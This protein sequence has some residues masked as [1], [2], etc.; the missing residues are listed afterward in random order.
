MFVVM[1]ALSAAPARAETAQ[2]ADVEES[3]VKDPSYKVRVEAAL[4][5][6]KLHQPRSL[7]ALLAGARDGHPAV[8]TASVRALGLTGGPGARDAV[9]AALRD[10]APGV[11]HRPRD[12]LRSLGGIDE[13]TPTAPGEP[14][15]RRRPGRQLSFEIRPVGDPRNQA[16]PLLRS[17]MRDFLMQQLRPLGDVAP[18][19]G[20]A[21]YAIG[22]VIKNLTVVRGGPA[23]EV[24]CAVELVVMR[25][26]G[27]ALFLMTSGEGRVQRPKRHFRPQLQASMELEAAEVAVRGASADLISQLQR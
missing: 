6:G 4:I 22:G 19:E 13:S 16:D 18:G 23:V 8:R 14:S 3:L 24:T 20:Q 1:L 15:I 5:L 7:P 27:N 17:H 12:A 2:I 11:R 9:L 26:P 25:Q 10:P 21:T